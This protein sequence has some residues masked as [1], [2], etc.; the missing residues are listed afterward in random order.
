MFSKSL[1]SKIPYEQVY[2]VLVCHVKRMEIEKKKRCY[3]S[4]KNKILQFV[5]E[6]VAMGQVLIM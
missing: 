1:E 5:A 2:N 4:I 6:K 3:D